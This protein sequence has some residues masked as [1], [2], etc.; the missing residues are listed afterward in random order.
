MNVVIK[1]FNVL[2]AQDLEAIAEIMNE[3]FIF[4]N[5][6]WIRNKEDWCNQIILFMF[7]C[8]KKVKFPKSTSQ[9]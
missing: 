3:N 4:L 8:N 2:E 5:N 9:R 6:Y 7:L 1:L